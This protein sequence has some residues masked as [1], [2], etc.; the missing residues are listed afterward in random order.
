M[1]NEYNQNPEHRRSLP[2]WKGAALLFLVLALSGLPPCISAAE[3]AGKKSAPSDSL[4]QRLK[5]V[6][7]IRAEIPDNARTAAILG[8]RRQ[9]SGIVIDDKG[10][11]LTIGYLVLEAKKISILTYDNR[12]MEALTIGY[13]QNT[14]FGLI[15]AA[16]PLG[17]KPVPLGDSGDIKASSPV[18]IISADANDD[19]HPAMVLSRRNY[20]GYWEY[21]VDNAIYTSPPTKF[22]SGAGLLD[23]NL[24]LVGI[25]YLFLEDADGK[26]ENT[27]GN[28][29]VP[30]NQFRDIKD[31]MIK[32]GRGP[33]PEKPWLGISSA[34]QFGRVMVLRV[35][36]RGPASDS[37]IQMGDI[38]LEV[39]GTKVGS[40]E[41]FY[42]ALWGLGGPGVDV[43]M[44]LLQR[45][46]LVSITV[47][48]GNR[49]DYYRMFH[50]P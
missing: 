30:I 10:H 39:G 38:I 24:N 44:K 1:T 8:G 41:E 31:D 6:V 9:G 28:M 22:F 48:S 26:G 2:G 42:R 14:G 20:A 18:V 37:G 13:D 46:N 35:T 17:I 7:S 43:K 33:G 47:K 4:E 40:L 12:E 25:G 15:R 21:M 5:A 34:E 3:E 50:G 45:N 27:P 49:M 19:V 32:K 29:F 16:E 23:R 11:I 36:S